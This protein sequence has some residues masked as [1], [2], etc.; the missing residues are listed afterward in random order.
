[1]PPLALREVR[2]DVSYLAHKR[3]GWD[4]DTQLQVEA[5][6]CLVSFPHLLTQYSVHTICNMLH[7]SCHILV[8]EEGEGGCHLQSNR[9]KEEEV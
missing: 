8:C 5:R 1:M 9:D 3:L 6:L 7:I 4:F 2:F